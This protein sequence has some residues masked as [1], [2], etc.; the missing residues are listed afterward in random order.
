MAAVITTPE[1]AQ[2]LAAVNH[3]NTFG[4]NPMSAAVGLAVLEVTINKYILQGVNY[5]YIS[6]FWKKK[7]YK[8]TPRQSERIS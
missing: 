4:G 3:F 5:V 8:R 7:S 1:I 6:R 2:S